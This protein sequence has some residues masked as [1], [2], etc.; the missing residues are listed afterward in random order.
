MTQQLQTTVLGRQYTLELS[1]PLTGYWLAFLRL[2]IGWWFLHAG[3]TKYATAGEF[4]AGWFL[5]QTGTIVSP[6]LN[7]VAGGWTEAVVN[8]VIP[9]GE[10]VIGLALIL[11]CLTRLASLFGA[12]QMS[13]FYLGNEAWRRSFVN[14]DLLGLL[15]FLTIMVFGAGRVWGIDAYLEQSEFVQSHWW[16]RYALG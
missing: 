13:F 15:F 11:G 2:L 16:L 14:G 10:V 7:A 3:L 9:A 6:I 1:G 8:A 12:V 4:E 5:T